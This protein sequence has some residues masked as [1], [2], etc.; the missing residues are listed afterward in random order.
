MTHFRAFSGTNLC[1]FFHDMTQNS[2]F[3][4][5]ICVISHKICVIRHKKFGFFLRNISWSKSIHKDFMTGDFSIFDPKWHKLLISDM[6]FHF[7]VDFLIF[8]KGIFDFS[9][10]FSEKAFFKIPK[11]NKSRI[12]YIRLPWFPE[13]KVSS[14]T[15][16]QNQ[17][18]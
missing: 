9:D 5:K 14:F 16:F 13:I 17:N 8:L 18:F 15:T 10:N 3:S 1:H 4:H 2:W 7:F 12:K 6:I 11:K